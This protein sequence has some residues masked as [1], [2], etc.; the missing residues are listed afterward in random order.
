MRVYAVIW[1]NAG[2]P[3]ILGLFGSDFLAQYHIAE[4]VLSGFE[5]S[6]LSYQECEVK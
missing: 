5:A 3:L 4:L 6:N 1:A 2:D